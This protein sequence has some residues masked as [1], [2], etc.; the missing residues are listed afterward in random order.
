MRNKPLI[1][2]LFVIPALITAGIY[3][4]ARYLAPATDHA[5]EHTPNEAFFYSSL[6]LKP[7]TNQRKAL[8]E[9]LERFPSAGTP[10]ESG[11]ALDDLLNATFDDLG[12]SYS[13]DVKPWVGT[14]IAFWATPPDDDT[15]DIGWALMIATKDEAAARAAVAKSDAIHDG[16]KADGLTIDG[17]NAFIEDGFVTLMNNSAQGPWKRMHQED[18]ISLAESKR[19]NG[20]IAQ[21]PQDRVAL[22]YFDPVTL[23]AGLETNQATQVIE[24]ALGPYATKPQA[25]VAY[26][27]A[28]AIV[29]ESVS[30]HALEGHGGSPD[31]QR[32]LLE[33]V[34]KVAWGA[35]GIDDFGTVVRSIVDRGATGDF[36]VIGPG[37]LR[38]TFTNETGLEL[39]ADLLDWMGD[40][41]VFIMGGAGP[42]NGGAILESTDPEASQRALRRIG[43]I[44]KLRGQTVRFLQAGLDGFVWRVPG[45]SS[46]IYAVS[47]AREPDRIVLGF[48]PPPTA[49]WLEA[50]PLAESDVFSAARAALGEGFATGFYLAPQKILEV[51]R[52]AGVDQDPTFEQD[53][54]PNLGVL[55]HIVGGSRVDGDT[56]YRRLVI[57]VK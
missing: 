9:L 51:M 56:V 55:S 3:V 8:R 43:G 18:A 21:L 57:G 36:G 46:P 41:G 25:A 10:E 2:S 28:D 32:G 11:Q 17:P 12:L 33:E 49:R 48:A 6:F 53:V 37:V 26:L 19:F 34:P 16:T 38:R 29:F 42:I 30:P 31:P 7:S 13:D 14:E 27:R 4:A 24:S 40:V 20:A 47:T 45:L 50:P 35:A 1:V 44:L 52:A 15:G 54:A 39:D 5:I 22:A 23:F